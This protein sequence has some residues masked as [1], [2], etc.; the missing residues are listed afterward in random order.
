MVGTYR[1]AEQLHD[2]NL[3]IDADFLDRTQT[4]R[5]DEIDLQSG[6]FGHNQ[7]Q[8]GRRRKVA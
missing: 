5:S 6:T 1:W 7:I 8:V 2:G 4:F 3:S